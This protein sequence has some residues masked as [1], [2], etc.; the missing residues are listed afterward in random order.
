[1]HRI[2][3]RDEGTWFEPIFRHSY[4]ESASEWAAMS[5]FDVAWTLIV[6]DVVEQQSKAEFH[7]HVM[8]AQKM[9]LREIW[10]QTFVCPPRLTGKG[11]FPTGTLVS[12]WSPLLKLQSMIDCHVARCVRWWQRQNLLHTRH[13]AKIE[14]LSWFRYS[15]LIKFIFYLQAP[16]IFKLFW[17]FA[18][19]ASEQDARESEMKYTMCT[20][21]AFFLSFYSFKTLEFMNKEATGLET[22]QEDKIKP[23][24]HKDIQ[25]APAKCARNVTR[26][27][28]SRE[29]CN[30]LCGSVE[31]QVHPALSQ[32]SCFSVVV[33]ELRCLCAV[34]TLPK[35]VC[36]RFVF[37]GEKLL[38]LFHKLMFSVV[39][40]ET[41][42]IASR[43]Y[44]RASLMLHFAVSLSTRIFF[45]PACLTSL[46]DVCNYLPRFFIIPPENLWNKKI[47]KSISASC[48]K[49]SNF[50]IA[51][52]QL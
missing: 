8:C 12:H 14:P 37:S 36:S 48:E 23:A 11:F 19:C 16:H 21:I 30:K 29:K 20:F 33:A 38:F 27:G 41:G 45:S 1:M 7:E 49:R 25:I 3:I 42:S 50:F 44:S 28:R 39:S 22:Q 34:F 6:S 32:Y 13:A 24:S 18:K 35:E 43:N 2:K 26:D 5:R 17:S 10:L 46:T 9:P 40:S 47:K 4:F 15:Q 51:P 52:T 31:G